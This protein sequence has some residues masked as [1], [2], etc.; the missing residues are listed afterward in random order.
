MDKVGDGLKVIATSAN[1]VAAVS[2]EKNRLYGVQFHPEVKL[3]THGVR[4]IENFL[5]G[6]CGLTG[7]FELPCRIS[8]CLQ[9]I[10]QTVGNRKVILLLS[11]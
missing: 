8:T 3:T 11:G 7:N 5:L 2:N 1:C 6:V 10:Q 9:T 4:M